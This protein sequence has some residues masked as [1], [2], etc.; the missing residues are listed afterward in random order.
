MRKYILLITFV[1]ESELIFSYTLKWSTAGV[2]KLWLA[3]LFCAAHAIL[4]EK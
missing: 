4:W 2:S 1:N 3:T